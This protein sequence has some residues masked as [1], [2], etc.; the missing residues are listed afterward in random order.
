[1]TLSKI[2]YAKIVYVRFVNSARPTY[3]LE[4]TCVLRNTF[5]MTRNHMCYHKNLAMWG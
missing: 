2:S 3:F 4:S 1:M 5:I